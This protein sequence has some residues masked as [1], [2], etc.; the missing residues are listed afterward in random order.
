[1]SRVDH[2]ELEAQIA[3]HLDA[4]DLAGA[5][6]E[7]IRGL[8]PQVLAYLLSLLRDEAIAADVFSAFCEDV[9]R[10]IGTFRRDASFRTWAY[11]LAWHA[12]AR[13]LRDPFRRRASRL[14]TDDAEKLAAE[15]RSTTALHL[16]ESSKD[17][18]AAMREALDPEDQTLL[19]LRIDRE[20]SWAEIARVLGG[21]EHAPSEAMLRK[22]FERLKDKL[23][24]EAAARGLLPE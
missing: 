13:S 11:T 16:R 1:V 12:A 17:A 10:G 15:V 3:A 23:R 20:F 4:G 7:G 24:E 6:T 9:W 21:E 2:S 18:L 22:R 14:A 8:G 5:A 19:V